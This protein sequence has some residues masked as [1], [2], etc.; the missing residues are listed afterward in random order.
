ML[1]VQEYL[2]SNSLELLAERFDIRYKIEDD[3]IIL[4]YTQFVSDKFNPIVQ[5]CRGLILSKDYKTVLC[6]PFNRFFNYGENPEVDDSFNFEKSNIREKIDGSLINIWWNPYKEKWICST[7]GNAYIE[8]E[9]FVR[10][11]KASLK[12]Y[13]LSDI[14]PSEMKDC[15]FCFELVSPETQVITY[16]PE[17]AMYFLAIFKN[18]TG[19][20]LD[21][22]CFVDKYN[23]FKTPKEYYFLDL[24]AIRNLIVDLNEDDEGFVV[25]DNT[26][27]RIKIKNPRY[28]ALHRMRNNGV[29][30]NDKIIDLV[31]NGEDSEY[32][33]YFPMDNIYIQVY[34]D[35]Y[36]KLKELTEESWNMYKHIEDKKE[37]ALSIQNE[38]YKSFLFA[39]KNGKSFEEFF[40]Q[41]STKS[42]MFLLDQLKE[43][44]DDSN[45][46]Y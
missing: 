4:N 17:P 12:N 3:C 24:E 15:T 19:E 34:K 22:K 31:I 20:E 26:G 9:K 18:S 45:T 46:I 21:R 28:V 29:L 16:Y 37:F 39:Y 36:N 33:V 11:I 43:D 23:I 35:A 13:T 40:K 7:R 6:K 10:N 1:K 14:F 44:I 32:L 30:S 5:E 41:L 8:D 42:K 27:T 2:Q 25:Q 38:K